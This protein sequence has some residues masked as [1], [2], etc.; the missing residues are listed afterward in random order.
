LVPGIRTHEIDTFLVSLMGGEP[1]LIQG[2][3]GATCPRCMR[4]MKFLLQ[5]GDVLALG[6]DAPV[7]YV[8]GCSHH[9][10]AVVQAFVDLY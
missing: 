7:L 8:Y 4:S 5:I 9:P 1:E 2:E 3:H 6:G 10:E